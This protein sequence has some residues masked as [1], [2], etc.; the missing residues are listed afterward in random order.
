M[1]LL[2]QIYANPYNR[3]LR[4]VYADYLFEKGDPRGEF[5]SLQ[6]QSSEEAIARSEELWKKHLPA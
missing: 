6:L 2:E 5:I 3:E 4:A 1:S